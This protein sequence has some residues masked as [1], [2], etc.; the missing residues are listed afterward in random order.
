[1]IQIAFRVFSQQ[2]FC[3]IRHTSTN[4]NKNKAAQEILLFLEEQTEIVS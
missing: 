4:T 3:M 2:C 1:M